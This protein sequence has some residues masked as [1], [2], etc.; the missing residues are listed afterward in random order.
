[1]LVQRTIGTTWML[2]A[3][4]HAGIF[5]SYEAI[6]LAGPSTTIALFEYGIA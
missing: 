6:G 3:L 2:W 5:V 4:V 1:L